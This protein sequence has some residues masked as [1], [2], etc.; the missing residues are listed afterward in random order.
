MNIIETDWKWNGALQRRPKTDYI[1]LHH[2]EAS[3]C[4]AKQVDEWHKNNGWSGIG[5]HF[6]VRKDGEVYRGRPIWAVGAQVQGHNL[7]SVGICAEGAYMK[8]FMPQK[9]KRAIAELIAELKGSYPNARIVGHGELG[10]SDCPGRNFPLAELKDYRRILDGGGEEM[11][12]EEKERFDK[13]SEDLTKAYTL[14]D[15]LNARI[16]ELENR[17]IYN[18]V[19]GN[20]PL[21]AHKGV[22]WCVEHGIIKGDERGLGLDDKDLRICTML[23]RMGEKKA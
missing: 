13:M 5:Y 22:E 9:Q 15:A 20:M 7:D 2:A 10:A 12:I 23:M 19:D 1:A 3:V 18:F 16:A 14:I 17:M 11:S 8:E 6:F 21:W 4:S